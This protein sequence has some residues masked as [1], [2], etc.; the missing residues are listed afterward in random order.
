M[1]V[2][3]IVICKN[4]VHQV[5]CSHKNDLESYINQVNDLTES[6]KVSSQGLFSTVTY[7][8]QYKFEPVSVPRILNDIDTPR[9]ED[10]YDYK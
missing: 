3:N 7:C 8:Q 9:E 1:K 2:E 5:V 6:F 10:D 4:C